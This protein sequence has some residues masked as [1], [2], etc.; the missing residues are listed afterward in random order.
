MSFILVERVEQPASYCDCG[1]IR[2]EAA[3]IGI[4]R[5]GLDYLHARH[6]QPCRDRQ[7]LNGVVVAGELGKG[8]KSGAPET[9]WEEA[10]RN[11]CEVS[12]PSVWDPG[13]LDVYW[14]NSPSPGVGWAGCGGTKEEMHYR[15]REGRLLACL[16]MST[17]TRKTSIACCMRSPSSNNGGHFA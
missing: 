17:T 8:R 4:E 15:Q 9:D 1:I 7:V 12:S 14:S 2:T 10:F 3:R 11:D 5:I 13:D 6:R 16:F